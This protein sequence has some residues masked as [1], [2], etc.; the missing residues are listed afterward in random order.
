MT[1]L[2]GAMEYEDR[3]EAPASAWPVFRDV[4]KLDSSERCIVECN[5]RIVCVTEPYAI[6]RNTVPDDTTVRG[7]ILLVVSQ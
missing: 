2:R 1:Q 3:S 6:L 5:S 4:I 7:C